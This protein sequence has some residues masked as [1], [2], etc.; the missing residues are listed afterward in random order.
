M[1]QTRQLNSKTRL[2]NNLNRQV[3]VVKADSSSA[4]V[5]IPSFATISQ[6]NGTETMTTPG[7][8]FAN[9]QND[10]K[11]VTGGPRS[12]SVDLSPEVTT[13]TFPDG[14]QAMYSNQISLLPSPTRLLHN[15]AFAFLSLLTPGMGAKPGRKIHFLFYGAESLTGITVE[16][17]DPRGNSLVA[18]SQDRGLDP[19]GIGEA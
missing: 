9:A 4:E 11:Q 7:F 6:S 17:M 19:A 1:L 12:V 13:I 5:I 14:Y 15:P 18:L 8:S 3:T 16:Y 2:E 10:I